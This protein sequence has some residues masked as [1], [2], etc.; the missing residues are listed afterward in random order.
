MAG[1]LLPLKDATDRLRPSRRRYLGA[2]PIEVERII[3]TDSR[4]G[5]FD[6][7]FRALKPHLR[8]RRRAL[9][10]AF[11]HG[12]FPPIAAEKLGDAYF[13]IDGHHRVALAR[14]MGMATIDAEVTE[15]VAR[16][17]LTAAADLTE[18]VHAEQ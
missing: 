12:D 3:G 14:Q 7:E 18:L 5:D 6:R 8:E 2:R 15:L 9:A 4:D 17:H 11:P 1:Q 16:W 10:A 13:V